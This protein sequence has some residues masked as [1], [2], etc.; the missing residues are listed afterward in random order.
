MP[1]PSP[2]TAD[3]KAWFT[4]LRAFQSA[5]PGTNVNK[6]DLLT[7]ANTTITTALPSTADQNTFIV[8]AV[9]ATGFNSMALSDLTT[10][11]TF[12]ALLDHWNP[13]ITPVAIYLRS[14]SIPA[15]QGA[16]SADFYKALVS[17]AFPGGSKGAAWT[18]VMAGLTSSFD[19]VCFTSAFQVKINTAVDA[20]GTK[21]SDLVPQIAGLG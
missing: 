4:H 18:K 11:K 3:L 9:N 5:C 6:I 14:L 7:F 8:S 1:S 20:A 21:I 19:P 15:L 13:L 10:Y 17:T 2:D 12:V 16:S